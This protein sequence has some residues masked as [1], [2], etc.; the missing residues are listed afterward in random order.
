MFSNNIKLYGKHAEILKKYAKD[1]QAEEQ[2]K[3]EVDDNIGETHNIYIFDTMIQAYMVA[4]M[5]GIINKTSIDKDE[6]KEPTANIFSEVLTKN[7]NL[8]ERIVRFLILTENVDKDVDLIIKEAFSMKNKEDIEKKV[9]SYA[10]Y[11]FEVIDNYFK[12]C[13][14][15]E[16]VANAIL[17]FKNDYSL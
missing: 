2:Y 11:G 4:A 14:T 13:A 5:I 12:D 8:L 3:F 16:D 1:K 17:C 7:R 15:Y 6:G 9:T 10:R